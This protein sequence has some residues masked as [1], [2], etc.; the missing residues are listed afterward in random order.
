MDRRLTFVIVLFLSVATP[1]GNPLQKSISYVS[2]LYSIQN[3]I[4]TKEQYCSNLL[5]FNNVYYTLEVQRNISGMP[6]DMSVH[7][8]TG[9]VFYTLISDSMRMSLQVLHD[10]GDVETVKTSGLGQSSAV[11]NINDIIY[12]ATDNGIYKYDDKTKT[13][14]L[15]TA[16]KEDVMYIAV[17]DRGA[18]IYIATWP[19]NRVHRIT[20]N[21]TKQETF[22]PIPNGHG[23]TVD[24]N[25]NIYFVAAKTTYVLKNGE[26]VPTKINGLPDNIVTAGVAVGASGNVY[27]MDQNSDLYQLDPQNADARYTGSFTVNGVNSFAMDAS[28][29][30]LI[31]VKDS[32]LK[33]IAH[34]TNPCQ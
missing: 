1:R 3:T 20:N 23:L 7:W 9:N 14:E 27:V 24:T 33:F 31:G 8:K 12:L 19:Q 22:P 30:I 26:T 29:N 13:A 16:A 6:A 17:G 25:D 5:H 4:P 34:D 15:Y 18:T 32:I 28:D 11:D 21:G 10:N 2:N